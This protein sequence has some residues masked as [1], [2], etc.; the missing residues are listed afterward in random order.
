[1]NSPEKRFKCGL[2]SASVFAEVKIIN[3]EEVK[4]FSINIARAYKKNKDDNGNEDS[5]WKYT[6]SFSPEDLP[7]VALVANEAYK[8]IRLNSSD[9]QANP[10]D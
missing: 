6:N 1:M 7:K 3:N 8:H 2:V 9:S 4:F 10:N 5:D